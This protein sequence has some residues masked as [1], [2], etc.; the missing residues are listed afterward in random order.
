MVKVQDPTAGKI[1]AQDL[2]ARETH[3]LKDR[4]EVQNYPVGENIVQDLPTNK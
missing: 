3:P 1:V 2:L 4:T